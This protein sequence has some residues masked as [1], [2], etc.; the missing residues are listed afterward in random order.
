M[1]TILHELISPILNGGPAAIIAILLL[2]AGICGTLYIKRDLEFKTDQK[3]M[4]KSFQDQ[5]DENRKDLL[6]VIDKY[7]QGQIGVIQAL[8]DLRVLIA[9]IGAKL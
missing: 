9:Q 3:E 7:Q 2:I 6:E 1:D 8:N 4:I 5:L